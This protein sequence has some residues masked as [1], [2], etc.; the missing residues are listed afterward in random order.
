MLFEIRVIQK[1][2]Q[3]FRKPIFRTTMIYTL[4]NIII[5]SLTPSFIRV[6]VISSIRRFDVENELVLFKLVI[7][8]PSTST[9]Y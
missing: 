3:F 2:I 5:I 7:I 8:L 6:F 1:G 4:S 9:K